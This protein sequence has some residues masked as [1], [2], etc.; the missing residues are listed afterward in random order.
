MRFARRNARHVPRSTIERA[1]ARRR[2]NS[3]LVTLRER[4]P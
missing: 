3:E 4:L 2:P 1:A